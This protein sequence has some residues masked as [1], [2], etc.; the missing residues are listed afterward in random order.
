[1]NEPVIIIDNVTKQFY[2]ERAKTLKSWFGYLLSPFKKFLV[3]K[4]FSLKVNKGEFVLITGS[5]GS[6]K[7]TLLRLIAGIT[8]PDKGKIITRGKI[9][10]L[11]ELSAGFNNELTGRE[12]IMTYATILGI[13]KKRI[14]EIIPKIIKFSGLHNFIDIPIKR[15]S[16]GMVSRLSFSIAVYSKPDI[17]LLDEIFAVGDRKFREKSMKL[18]MR[19]KK[20][21]VTI[22][23][24]THFEGRIKVFDKQISLKPVRLNPSSK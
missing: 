2:L 22:I 10:P 4:D 5:N 3:L 12:N 14:Y 23:L 16:T 15:Y 9:V 21:G 1:M 18:L 17:L 6:G 13:E 19:F 24:C 11:I 20:R 7:T 8:D